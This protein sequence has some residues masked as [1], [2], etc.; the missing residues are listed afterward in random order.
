[1]SVVR[2]GS[3]K[4]FSDNWDNIFAGS[5]KG[6]SKKSAPQRVGA[7]KA[8]AK[9]AAAKNSGSKRN[10]PAKSARPPKATGVDAPHA[11]KRQRTAA[12]SQKSKGVGSETAKK[13]A[14][15]C[16]SKTARRRAKPALQQKE[17]F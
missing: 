1:M 4:K 16:K 9:P 6:G 8:P 10:Q 2:V 5:G 3:T 17:L 12:A 7:K 15:K 14:A 13:S 11:K